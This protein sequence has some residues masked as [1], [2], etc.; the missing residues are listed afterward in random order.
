MNHKY[1]LN[2]ILSSFKAFKAVVCLFFVIMPLAVSSQG[3]K[4]KEMKLVMSDLS[5]SVNQRNDYAGTPCGMVKVIVSNPEIS[6]GNNVVGNVENKTNEYWVYLPKGSKELV[7]K[8]Q[9]YLPMTVRFSDYG[10]DEIDSK[11]TYQLVL[12][13]VSFNADKNCVVINATPKNAQLKIDDVVVEKREEGS[14]KMYLEKGEHVVRLET[15]GYRTGIEVVKTGKGLQTIDVILESLMAKVKIDCQTTTAMIYANDEKLGT[16]SWEGDLVAGEYSIEARKEGFITKTISASFAEKETKVIDIPQLERD[17]VSFVI[18]TTPSDC[19]ERNVY[20]DGRVEGHD[21]II[22]MSLPY[23]LHLLKVEIAGCNTLE[24]N[25]NVNHNIDTL[26]YHLIP[27]NRKYELAYKGDFNSIMDLSRVHYLSGLDIGFDSE[28][29]LEDKYW[30][31][32]IKER[33]SDDMVLE[34]LSRRDLEEIIVVGGYVKDT[35]VIDRIANYWIRREDCSSNS[36][37]YAYYLLAKYEKAIT[38]WELYLK[39]LK[40]DPEFLDYDDR[41][42][43]QTCLN[44]YFC[45][46]EMGDVENALQWLYNGIDI[47]PLTDNDGKPI[48]YGEYLSMERA[49]GDIFFDRNNTLEAIKWY[50]RYYRD[51]T[52]SCPPSADFVKEMKRKGIYDKVVGN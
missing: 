4:I 33:L 22:S 12:K 49:I 52:L 46:K 45:Y 47:Y 39:E 10:I 9:N 26:T 41:P 48:I 23:G 32:K 30:L 11:V 36:V 29:T 51:E 38:W 50:R 37:A 20:V 44:I 14:Y 34:D 6:F 21:S 24:E 18:K 27:K 7:I 3:L 31:A 8:R 28:I 13:E 35:T 42:A 40:K 15:P 17:M 19:F 25:I 2:M 43:Y 1:Q 16:G 5:A